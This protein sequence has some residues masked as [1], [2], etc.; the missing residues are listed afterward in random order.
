GIFEVDF[1]EGD[2]ESIAEGMKR[3]LAFGVTR[4]VASTISRPLPETVKQIKQLRQ[5]KEESRYGRI[6]HGVHLEGPWLAPRCRGG[7]PLE[8]LRVP[9]KEDVAFVLGEVGDVLVT[10][11][12]APELPN[13]VWLTETLACRG[14]LPVIGHTE[15]TYEE[16]ERSI[17]AGARHV[18][19]MYDGML[20]YRENPREAL[21]MLPGVE[22]AVLSH[23]TVSVE[24]IGCPIHVPPPFFR[25]IQQVKPSGKKILVTDSLV[26]TGMPEG[27]I[28]RYR[29]GRKV[30][31]A[32]NVIRMIDEDPAIDGNLTGSAVTMNVALRRL[33][34]YAEIPLEE[35]LA[36][37]TLNP[38]RVLG[39]DREVGSIAVGKCADL[40]V[41]DEDFGVR[42]TVLDGNVVFQKTE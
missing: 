7:H 38:A 28:L 2:F 41:I 26:G 1:V 13:A 32:G 29:D 20:G 42:Y 39:I 5:V 35:A 25:F 21:V 15:A 9:T 36:W 16:A 22:T 37:G 10:V 3:Y 27:S 8:Y 11:T 40:A 31:V 33:M 18:T 19:H 14:I 4:V 34:E 24:L 6:L 23:D 17:L 30:R 12:F